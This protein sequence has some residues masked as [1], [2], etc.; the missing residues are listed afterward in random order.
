MTLFE[1]PRCEYSTKKRSSIRDHYRRKTPCKVIHTYIPLKEC[2]KMLYTQE[3]DVNELEIKNE[4]IYN[5]QKQI[6]GMREQMSELIKTVGGHNDN[7]VNTNNTNSNNIN[8]ITNININSYKDTDYKIVEE[9][10]IACIQGNGELDIGQIIKAIHFN[11]DVPQNHN[12]Y[13]SNSKS[14]KVMKYDGEKF[15]ESGKN[16]DGIDDVINEKLKDI[17]E[18]QELDDDL[19]YA[20]DVTWTSFTNNKTIKEKRNIRNKVSRE[21][22]NNRELIKI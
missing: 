5:M 12:L 1:C 3:E 19:K 13:I 4:I 8:N 17:D 6:D 22:Y 10:L 2:L 15:I 9:A 16:E 21:M 20:S 18:H 11:K 7:S 14:S